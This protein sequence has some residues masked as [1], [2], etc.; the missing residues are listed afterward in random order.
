MSHDVNLLRQRVDSLEYTLQ[1]TVVREIV[2]SHYPQSNALPTLDLN[3]RALLAG[4]P[5]YVKEYVHRGRVKYTS[6]PGLY[7]PVGC[8]A[9]HSRRHFSTTPAST[10]EAN[11]P[12]AFI[13]LV[14][15]DYYVLVSDVC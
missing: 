7:L 11:F 12:V 13:R 9:L 4:D 10:A 8:S 14:Y 2:H 3:C 15:C 6:D 5:E 1:L